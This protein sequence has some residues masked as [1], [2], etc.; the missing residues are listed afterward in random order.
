MWRDS[1]PLDMLPFDMTI[2]ATVSQRLV[3]MEGLTN[4]PVFGKMGVVW[5][6]YI[7]LRQGVASCKQEEGPLGSIKFRKFPGRL[8]KKFSTSWS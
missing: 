7:C 2:P 3:I 1:L 6:G 4:Y 8:L 5:T